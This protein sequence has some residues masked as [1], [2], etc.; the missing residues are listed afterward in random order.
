MNPSPVIEIRGER[1]ALIPEQEYLKLLG[2]VAPDEL[3]EA[4]PFDMTDLVDADDFMGKALG[5]TLKAA[6]VAAGLTQ[7]Q[8]AK[9][10]KK[11]QAMVSSAERGTIEIGPSYLRSVLKG[12]GLP[13]TWTPPKVALGH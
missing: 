2:H 7:A 10:I 3:T 4:D 8:L 13:M 6:R 9:K 11:S 1:F 5:R 12:C